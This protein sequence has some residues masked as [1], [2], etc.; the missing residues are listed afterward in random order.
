MRRE[1][2]FDLILISLAVALG[3]SLYV[4]R[5]QAAVTLP[6]ESRAL[7]RH[8]YKKLNKCA[9]V[10]PFVRHQVSLWWNREKNI[11]AK[12]LKLVYADCM[13][14]GCDASILL[15]GP[16]TEK[17][18]A[19][20]SGLDGF[21]LIDKI[22]KVLEIR[23]PRAVSCANILHLATRD[24]LYFAGGPSYPV[25]LGRR[26][27]MESKAS[28]VDLPSP[29][30]SIDQGIT[31][32]KSKG[33]DDMDYATLLGAHT[34]GKTHCAN[35][36]DRLYNF[37]K[38][39]KPDPSIAKSQLDELRKQCPKTLKKGQK[40][41]T[42]FLTDDQY[43]FSNKYYSNLVSNKAVLKVDQDLL[44][45]YNTS[46][47]A[48]EYAAMFQHLKQQF[49]LSISRLGGLKVLTGNQGEIRLNCRFTNKNNPYT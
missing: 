32:F 35:L 36:N 7:Q 1:G 31:Y 27:G 44:Q 18:S 17:T 48:H 3:L 4:G 26:D 16:H 42:M 39:R 2:G 41:P 24:A 11:T 23:C 13:V 15:D 45:S 14:N 33:L 10:E 46:E 34:M 38:T 19:K 40:D 20:N 28:W 21:L 29:A 47:L 9:N 12:L 22:K 43:R 6:P 8:F 49:S 37:N 5:M 25:Y 30:I